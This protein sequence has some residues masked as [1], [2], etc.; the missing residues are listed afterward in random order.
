MGQIT[1]KYVKFLKDGKEIVCGFAFDKSKHVHAHICSFLDAGQ[2]Y[3]N[4]VSSLIIRVLSEGDTVIDI[5]ANIGY[6]T[7]LAAAMVG[8]GGKVLAFEPGEEN[9]ADLERNMGMNRIEGIVDIVSKPATDLPKETS[10]YLNKT[11]SG[12][13][14]LWDPAE[15][16]K[17]SDVR[18]VAERIS[19]QSTTVDIEVACRKIEKIKLI[20]IDTEGA[21]AMILR[22][23]A[24]TLID[25]EVDFVVCELHQ[26]GLEQLGY[27]QESLRNFMHAMGYECFVLGY[28]AGFPWFVPK[29]VK[30]Q[31]SH[32]CNVLFAK[33]EVLARYWPVASFSILDF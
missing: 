11:S 29:G 2:F 15:F 13:N 5:G 23:A 1:N 20:K 21:E 14:A 12:G 32:I 30:I 6:F 24:R 16:S 19:L 27:S 22:G 25:A 31:A 33:P 26:F 4:D 9:I 18:S 10:F 8:K 7:V 3:E 17:V 28:K